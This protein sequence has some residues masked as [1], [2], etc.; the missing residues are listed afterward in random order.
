VDSGRQFVDTNVLVYARDASAGEKRRT[1]GAL[2]ARLWDTG[3]ACASIQVLQEFYVAV[4][5][6]ASLPIPPAEAARIVED[7]S[8]WTIFVPGAADVLASIELQQ[9]LNISFWDAMILRGAAQLDCEVIWSEDLKRGQV[10]DG[11]RV[12]NPFAEVLE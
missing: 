12:A 6:K 2:L 10:Y 3:V 9:R 11:V 7:V 8:R 4:T 5:R 1:A